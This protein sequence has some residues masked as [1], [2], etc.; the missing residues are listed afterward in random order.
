M[1]EHSDIDATVV[2]W[3]CGEQPRPEPARCR[4]SVLPVGGEGLPQPDGRCPEGE[5]AA[6]TGPWGRD[7]VALDGSLDVQ[8]TAVE[9]SE[10]QRGELAAGGDPDLPDARTAFPHGS[11]SSGGVH[12]ATISSPDVGM[13]VGTRSRPYMPPAATVSLSPAETFCFCSLGGTRTPNL[14]IRIF[15]LREGAGHSPVASTAIRRRPGRLAAPLAAPF[16]V[17]LAR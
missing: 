6:V 16:L 15:A 17:F 5:G 4:V 1:A 9:V 3:V 2:A 7:L 14:L 13:N 11:C 12:R 10:L 8:D